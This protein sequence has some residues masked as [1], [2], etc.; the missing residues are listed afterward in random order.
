MCIRDSL[1]AS[2][3]ESSSELTQLS[4]AQSCNL[5][6]LTHPLYTTNKVADSGPHSSTV[7]LKYG[8]RS[9]LFATAT[10]SMRAQSGPYLGVLDLTRTER[11]S[12]VLCVVWVRSIT[13][14]PPTKRCAPSRATSLRRCLTSSGGAPDQIVLVAELCYFCRANTRTQLRGVVD[15]GIE[16]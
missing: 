6:V 13:C 12:S 7:L 10:A 11:H 2:L 5:I 9:I 14:C 3:T 8:R 4:S 15:V 1:W 16:V